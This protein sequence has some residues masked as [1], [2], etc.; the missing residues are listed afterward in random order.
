ML[1]R[2]WRYLIWG[3]ATAGVPAAVGSLGVGWYSSEELLK[4]N[5]SQRL[6]YDVEVLGSGAEE[7]K[8]SPSANARKSGTYGLQWVGAYGQVGR[9]LNADESGVTREFRPMQGTPRPGDALLDS[10][11]FPHN[12]KRAF[13]M[14]YEEITVASELGE[15]PTWYLEGT[16]DTWMIFVHGHGAERGEAL[17]ILPTIVGEGLPS[18]VI[19]YRND[20]EAPKSPDGL[21]HLGQTE[22]RD[23]E[24]AADYALANGAKELV[25]VG[26][27]MGGAITCTFLRESER[28]GK[29][30]G[31]I[32]DAPALVWDAT[33]AFN[34]R[35]RHLPGVVV[36]ITKFISSFRAGGIDW[37]ALDQV[38]HAGEFGV[39]IL[40]F[41]GD[42]DQTVPVESS[43]SFAEARP[44]LVTYQRVHGAGHLESW[45]IDPEDYREAVE[46]FLLELS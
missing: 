3:V 25:V 29:V 26:Y 31:V 4:P 34:A 28:A 37:S 33:L 41:H 20:P 32:L 42:R 12:P 43:D 40:L 13:H 5:P 39:P 24:A 45:N 19:T 11:A 38:K 35:E 10:Y 14:P 36:S 1:P 21:Y 22:W 44:D 9:I 7:V 30:R 18:L 8:L 6:G 27:S 2:A 17:R 15:L 46:R 16:K 23:L